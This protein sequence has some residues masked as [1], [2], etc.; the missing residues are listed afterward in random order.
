MLE[1]RIEARL[2]DGAAKRGGVAVKLG[3]NGQPDRIVFLPGGRVGLA[4]LKR[5]KRQAEILQGYYLDLYT[6]LGVKAVR[7]NTLAGVDRFLEELANE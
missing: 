3:N 6:R 1:E 7:I 5:P 2:V 4:E